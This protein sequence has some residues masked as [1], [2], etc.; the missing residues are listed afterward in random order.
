MD[1]SG[2]TEPAG[3]DNWL[4]SALVQLAVVVP[5]LAILVSS[6]P[7]HRSELTPSVAFFVAAVAVIDLIPVPGWGGLQLSLS[8]PVLL[9][10]AILYDPSIAAGIAFLGSFDPR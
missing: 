10:V 2:T 7:R 4:G 5:L 3:R 6:I 1:G 8:F 9:G